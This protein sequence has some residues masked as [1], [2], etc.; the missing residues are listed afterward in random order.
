M[1]RWVIVVLVLVTTLMM[2]TS[3]IAPIYDVKGIF[4][5]SSVF[6]TIGRG[7]TQGKLPY[8]DFFDHKGPLLYVINAIGYGLMGITGVWMIEYLFLLV[9]SFLAFHIVKKLL[10]RS[11]VCANL[12][13]TLMSLSYLSR[14]LEGGNF[15]EEYALLFM[16]SGLYIFT[17]VFRNNFRASTLDFVL[18]GIAFGCTLLLRPNMFGIWVGFSLVFIHVGIQKKKVS[19]LKEI[20]IFIGATLFCM[21]PFVWFLHLNGALLECL[22]QYLLFNSYYISEGGSGKELLINI[23]KNARIYLSDVTVAIPSLALVFLLYEKYKKSDNLYYWAVFI[24]WLFSIFMI[25]ISNAAYGHYKMVFIPLYLPIFSGFYEEYLMDSQKNETPLAKNILLVVVGLILCID[26][27]LHVSYFIRTFYS[28]DN[29]DLEQ[30]KYNVESATD[31]DDS[32]V[33]IG[34]QCNIYLTIDRTPASK[35]I[36]QFPVIRYNEEI[37]KEFELDILENNV[38]IVIYK[39]GNDVLSYFSEEFVDFLENHYT[40]VSDENYVVLLLEDGGNFERDKER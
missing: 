21:V 4:T 29:Q 6:L 28:M 13:I 30:L 24:S 8:I 7:I 17:K 22:N 34:N 23:L 36:Y 27:V 10:P 25:A 5:D 16:M 2:A 19:L 11:S 9:T 35:Y 14:V 33:V 15:T 20:G 3:P 38:N 32:M 40:T 1:E 39:E 37:R 18:S 31:T 12:I 26:N